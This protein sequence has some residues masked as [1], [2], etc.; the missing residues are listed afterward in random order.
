MR[1]AVAIPT[2]WGR[3]GGWQKGDAIY[4]HPTPL[5]GQDTL[6]RFLGS[7]SCLEPEEDTHVVVI[8]IPTAEDIADAV[9]FLAGEQSKF[10]HGHMLQV[11]SG[12]TII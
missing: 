3:S 9:V 2:Y 6:G 12:E 5:G 1:L 10:V 4:D 11:D 7:L 8:A